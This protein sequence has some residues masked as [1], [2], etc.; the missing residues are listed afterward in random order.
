MDLIDAVSANTTA[1][2][3]VKLSLSDLFRRKYSSLTDVLSSLF[4]TNLKIPPTIED[5]REQT[6]RVTQLLA[7]ACTPNLQKNDFALFAIDC[8][9][10]P[11]VYAT[12]VDDRSIVHAPNH[13]PGQKP[14]TAGHEYSVLVYLPNQAADRDLHWVVPLSVKRV[15]SDQSGPKV[16]LSQLEE[17]SNQTVFKNCFC[18]NVSDAAYSTKGWVIGVSQWP[19]VVQIA[20]MRGNRKLF[21]MPPYERKIRRGRPQI[22]GEELLL[23][24]PSQPDLEEITTTT[25]RKGSVYQVL[26]QRWND[27]LMH[28]SQE[29]RTHK[30][31]FDLLRITVTDKKG[32]P[33]YRRPLWVMI[34]G[35]KRRDVSSKEAYISYGR[36]YDIEHFFRF[37]KQRLGLVN[38]QTCE[39]R[40]EENWHWIGLLAYNMLYHTRQLTKPVI[41]PWEKK[42]VR[43]V[44]SIQRP[45]QVQRDYNRIIQGIGTPAP[46]PKP[47]GKSPGRQLGDKSGER[48]NRPLIRKSIKKADAK[49]SSCDAVIKKKSRSSSAKAKRVRIK[50]RRMQRVWPKNR[51]HLCD[52]RKNGSKKNLKRLREPSG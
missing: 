4:R 43:V 32:K 47:R 8:T 51:P 49:S 46:M 48:P 15:E 39:T 21:R 12:K 41:Y 27:V 31:P 24:C 23:K 3:V 11:R 1:D 5:R 33:V 16:G 25:T 36:R 10:N 7:E 22:Y 37:G 2:S 19:H 18:V 14:I 30:H 29:E 40:H 13:V 17:I 42:K 45:S 38:S 44:T 52:A 34:A 50:Y 28:G 20:R 26:L 9:A 35:A 6:L